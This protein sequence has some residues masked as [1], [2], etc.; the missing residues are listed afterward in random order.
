MIAIAFGVF[1]GLVLFVFGLP[2][3]CQIIVAIVERPPK[4]PKPPKPVK[5]KWMTDPET[6]RM[7]YG[8]S[9]RL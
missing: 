2:V 7:A 5:P 4:P 3:I 9:K 1:F 8:K 6:F